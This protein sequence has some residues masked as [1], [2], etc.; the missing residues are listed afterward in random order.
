[1]K[2]IQVIDSGENC[3]Y[4]IFQATDEEFALIFPDET[5][6]EFIEDFIARVDEEIAIKTLDPIWERRLDKKNIKGIHGTLFYD[7]EDKKKYYPTK[8][9]AEMIAN[10]NDSDS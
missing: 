7:L 5:D 3:T 4:D 10:P 2:N 9:D 8:K 1:M 6:I